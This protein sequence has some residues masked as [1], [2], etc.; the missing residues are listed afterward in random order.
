M[1]VLLSLE[2]SMGLRPVTEVTKAE[3][4]IRVLLFPGKLDLKPA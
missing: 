1:P 2:R 3:L 4:R